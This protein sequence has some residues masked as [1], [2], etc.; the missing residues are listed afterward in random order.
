MS[1][2]EEKPPTY[3]MLNKERLSARKKLWVQKN[4]QKVLDINKRYR[5]RNRQKLAA[6]N[7]EYR[8][9]GYYKNKLIQKFNIMKGE[10][11]LDNV[12]DEL[13]KEFAELVDEMHK[14]KI[15]DDEE[16]EML[17]NYV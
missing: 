4:Y 16:Y 10:I 5:E 12:S 11:L 7:K 13:L 2:E 17:K 3:Y 6:A 14:Y 1:Q 8:R 15:I 9:V